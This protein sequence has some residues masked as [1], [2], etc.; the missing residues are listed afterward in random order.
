M[1]S[2]KLLASQRNLIALKKEMAENA[3]RQAQAM[4]AELQ[5]TINLCASELGIDLKESWNLSEDGGYFEKREE[6]KEGE[7]QIP[8]DVK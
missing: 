7:V 2:K 5:Q 1:E 4:N 3:I 8:P 6:R